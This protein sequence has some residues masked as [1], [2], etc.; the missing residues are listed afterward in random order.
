MTAKTGTEQ[1][2]NISSKVVRKMPE[3]WGSILYKEIQL[4]NS[5]T[6][7]FPFEKFS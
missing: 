3:E 4:R 7:S 1:N 6:G 2:S 5:E